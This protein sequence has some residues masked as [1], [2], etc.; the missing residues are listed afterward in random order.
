[1][2]LAFTADLFVLANLSGALPVTLLNFNGNRV[3]NKVLL[4]WQV[5]NEI[6]FAR[7]EVERSTT[8]T[9]FT[10]IGTIAANGSLIP[11]T[12]NFED[13]LLPASE[14]LYYRLKL[15]NTDGRFKYSNTIVLKMNGASGNSIVVSPNPFTNKFTIQYQS[16]INEKIQLQLLDMNGRVIQQQQ[17]QV[18]AGVNQLYVAADQLATGTYVV[19]VIANGTVVNQKIIKQ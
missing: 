10:S 3:N 7:Y 4:N 1:M 19:K 5:E 17:Y 2:N 14:V 12:Y 16:P 18:R 11:L 6:S 9:N 13:K 15:I 8:G